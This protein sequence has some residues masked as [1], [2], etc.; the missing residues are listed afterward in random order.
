MGP[1]TECAPEVSRTTTTSL[2]SANF[3]V[4]T[5]PAQ[6]RER[7]VIGAGAGLAENRLGGAESQRGALCRTLL[8]PSCLA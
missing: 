5:E 8:R 1:L 2:R 4:G 3:V 7:P 6:M